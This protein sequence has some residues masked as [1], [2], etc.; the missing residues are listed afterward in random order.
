MK[1]VPV[2]KKATVKAKKKDIMGIHFDMT[3]F[4]ARNKSCTEKDLDDLLGGFIE[5]VESKGMFCCGGTEL[6]KIN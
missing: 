4:K 3:C 2:K 5:Y 1:K 6:M